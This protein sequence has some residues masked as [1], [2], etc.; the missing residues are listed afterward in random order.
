VS[1]GGHL[2]LERA[3]ALLSLSRPRDGEREARRGLAEEPE[4]AAL[5]CVLARCLAHQGEAAAVD[6]A[7][8]AV[9][10]EPDWAYAHAVLA[11]AL[12]QVGR[13]SRSLP[14]AEAAVDE[15]LRLDPNSPSC[16]VLRAEVAMRQGGWELALTAVEQ[17]I[18]LD[19]EHAYSHYL[20]ARALLKLDRVDE[21]RRAIE[22]A[23]AVDAESVQAHA[24]RA[25]IALLDGDH[26]TATA[27]F[28]EALRLDPEHR[29][30][31]LGLMEAIGTRAP[32]YWR[33]LSVRNRVLAWRAS[34][35]AK[36]MLNKGWPVYL[37]PLML[38]ALWLG[39]A[40]PALL[41]LLTAYLLLGL[42]PLL[43]LLL[44]RLDRDGSL[45]LSRGEAR[46][47]VW[48]P[49]GLV[50]GLGVSAIGVVAGFMPW[51]MLGIG[52]LALAFPVAAAFLL[53]DRRLSLP[54]RRHLALPIRMLL[55]VPCAVAAA[56]LLAGLAMDTS[57]SLAGENVAALVAGFT[58]GPV[59][60]EW[61]WP[62]LLGSVGALPLGLIGAGV[63]FMVHP[64]VYELR[65][66]DTA[67]PA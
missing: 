24:G 42:P 15:A 47:A 67:S 22:S 30:A 33:L 60:V 26:A 53:P 7:G 44:T 43:T 28:R 14:D 25:W 49:T 10:L 59:F 62:L 29:W 48:G 17:A 6:V 61:N 66:G 5:H 46:A 64:G 40:W 4:N 2:A 1:A 51:L 18:A 38:L 19:P 36:A 31:R 35:R 23:L 16:H 34:G 11:V 45:L 55:D 65:Y 54:W 3:E 56:L 9:R 58:T 8:E 20:R 50:I 63:L 21:A 12:L 57:R 41:L 32:L 37:A 27:G 39:A 13:P 52:L